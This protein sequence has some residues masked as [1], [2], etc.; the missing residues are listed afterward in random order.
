MNDPSEIQYAVR[1]I[2]SVLADAAKKHD[3]ELE[4]IA[5]GFIHRVTFKWLEKIYSFP[6]M[7][8]WTQ[9]AIS[10]FDEQGG[11][12]I[13]CFCRQPDLLSQWRGY[14]AV[15]GGYA[16]GFVARELARASSGILLRKVVY[17]RRDQLNIP[18]RWAAGISSA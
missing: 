2:E 6:K 16:V 13:A 9:N 1:L 14:G 17:D 18:H 11:A 5:P 15:G 3:A 7:K 10:V 4:Q 8:E 12:Y